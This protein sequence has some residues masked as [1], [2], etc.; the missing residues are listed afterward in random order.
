ME[1]IIP[2]VNHVILLPV[3]AADTEGSSVLTRS[4]K[5]QPMMD[6]ITPVNTSQI[7]YMN[8]LGSLAAKGAESAI[9][10]QPLAA[11]QNQNLQPVMRPEELLV[12]EMTSV[13]NGAIIN[14]M[15]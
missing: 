12:N 6:F 15:A 1:S 14:A 9:P 4:A 3:L 13:G 7:T 8:Y 10:L 5:E 2:L 11:V